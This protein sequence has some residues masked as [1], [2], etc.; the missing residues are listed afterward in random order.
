MILPRYVL[1][2][3]SRVATT[4]ETG[5]KGWKT[6]QIDACTSDSR[7]SRCRHRADAGPCSCTHSVLKNDEVGRPL[8]HC[9]RHATAGCM[10][11]GC[12]AGG[13]QMRLL[14]CSAPQHSTSSLQ[15]GP[16]SG[17]CGTPACMQHTPAVAVEGMSSQKPATSGTLS[18]IHVRYNKWSARHSGCQRTLSIPT[19][20]SG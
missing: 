10:H 8:S 2:R 16:S 14:H 20:D 12:Q 3:V 13:W 18:S 19:T 6:L 4:F 1:Q 17:G 7:P 15:R 5:M 11:G 9:F